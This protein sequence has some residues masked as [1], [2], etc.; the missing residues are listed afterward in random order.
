MNS[1]QS[2]KQVEAFDQGAGVLSNTALLGPDSSFGK[3]HLDLWLCQLIV[4]RVAPMSSV[5]RPPAI[6]TSAKIAPAARG[7]RP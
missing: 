6:S 4:R 7:F 1:S 5:L 2:Q 3:S